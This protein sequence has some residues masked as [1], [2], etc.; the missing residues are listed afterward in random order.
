[1]NPEDHNL[2]PTGRALYVNG[3]RT[4]SILIN[5]EEHLRFTSKEMNGEFGSYYPFTFCLFVV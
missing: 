2:W 5:E 4:Q 3:A 1:M